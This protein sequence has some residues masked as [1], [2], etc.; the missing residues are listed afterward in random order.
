[1]GLQGIDSRL[2]DIQ[3]I[4]LGM[5]LAT[6]MLY[7]ERDCAEHVLD[8]LLDSEKIKFTDNYD[9]LYFGNVAKIIRS[10]YVLKNDGYLGNDI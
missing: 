8:D 5:N 7:H 10:G 9:C 3:M 4:S 2:N 6:K 1:M